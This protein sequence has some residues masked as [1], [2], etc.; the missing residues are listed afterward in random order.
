VR[1]H[2]PDFTIS[3][4]FW[5]PDSLHPGGRHLGFRDAQFDVREHIVHLLLH[6]RA[7]QIGVLAH[8]DDNND[9][10]EQDA[11]IGAKREPFV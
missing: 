5:L 2:H 9:E 7:C 8:F 11:D 1:V 4:R 10:A 6:L 3:E